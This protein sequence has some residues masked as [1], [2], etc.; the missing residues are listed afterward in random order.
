MTYINPAATKSSSSIR[1]DKV[2]MISIL[3]RKVILL[4]TIVH[5]LLASES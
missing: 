5:S 2:M 3:L 1:P 4:H